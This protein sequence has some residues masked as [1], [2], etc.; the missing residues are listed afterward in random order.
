LT[1]FYLVEK[2][3]S[4]RVGQTVFIFVATKIQQLLSYEKDLFLFTEHGIGQPPFGTRYSQ[5][6]SA[7]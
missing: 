4:N 6:I 2:V 1:T 5:K 3:F 7:H